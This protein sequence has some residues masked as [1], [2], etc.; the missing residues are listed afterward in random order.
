M[1]LG[2]LLRSEGIEV[3]LARGGTQVPQAVARFEPDVIFLGLALAEYDGLYVAQTLTRYFGER[4]PLLIAL[5]G[6]GAE[7]DREKA[8]AS[9]FKH[10]FEKPYN[11]EALLKLV[12]SVT[13]R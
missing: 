12:L 3:Q 4:C 2:I 6:R 9:G 13:P 1:T 10:Y 8:T 5:A 7:V 11:P